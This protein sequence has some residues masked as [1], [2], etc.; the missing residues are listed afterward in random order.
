MSLDWRNKMNN[1][2]IFMSGIHGV[3]KTTIC[4]ELQKSLNL[5]FY[6]ASQII[7]NVKNEVQPIN[8]KIKNI[9]S[10]QDALILGLQ[11]VNKLGKPFILDGHFCLFDAEQNV[12]NIPE[13]TF[14]DINPMVIILI[15]DNVEEIFSRVQ[16]RDNNTISLQALNELQ[17]NEINYAKEISK[18]LDVELFIHDASRDISYL[19]DFIRNL[20]L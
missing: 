12:T 18:K 1:N 13:K 10:N 19:V 2:T 7:N 8:K 16:K 15:V 11:K 6:S 3:G 14:L 4:I 5:S 9:D 20:K 17:I